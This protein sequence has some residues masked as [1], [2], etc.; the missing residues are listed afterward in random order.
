M[1]AWH[2]ADQLVQASAKRPELA[3]LISTFRPDVP[4]YKVDVDVEKARTLNVPLSDAYN[5]LQTFLGGLYVNDFNLFGRTWQALVQ[6]DPEFR[7]RPADIDRFYTRSSD[8]NMC[9]WA[10]WPR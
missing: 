6:A 4:A 3:N 7:S 2:R 9:R 8:G 1:K 10:R 5:T